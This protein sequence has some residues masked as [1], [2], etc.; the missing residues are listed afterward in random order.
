MALVRIGIGLVLFAVALTFTVLMAQGSPESDVYLVIAHAPPFSRAEL[1]AA[2]E[3][4]KNYTIWASWAGDVGI[5]VGS[6]REAIEKDVSS[7]GL[8]GTF[9]KVGDKPVPDVETVVKKVGKSYRAE[10]IKGGKPNM[11]Y[12]SEDLEDVLWW[13][14]NVSRHVDIPLGNEIVWYKLDLPIFWFAYAIPFCNGTYYGPWPPPIMVAGDT[15]VRVQ[16]FPENRTIVPIKLPKPV[17]VNVTRVGES[18]FG[19]YVVD[20]CA[21]PF[22]VEKSL[23]LALVHKDNVEKVISILSQV[24]YVTVRAEPATRR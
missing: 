17:P 20:A 23:V 10:I 18:W 21:L 6:S 13:I 15:T 22:E 3:K 1:L 5:A 4:I 8:H 11:T 16:V 12:V 19:H 7:R 2:L 9:L 14:A 24:P